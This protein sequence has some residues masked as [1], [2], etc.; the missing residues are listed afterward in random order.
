MLH[1]YSLYH[2][3]IQ[4]YNFTYLIEIKEEQ[5]RNILKSNTIRMRKEERKHGK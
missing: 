2:S 5:R 4:V 1:K 3:A